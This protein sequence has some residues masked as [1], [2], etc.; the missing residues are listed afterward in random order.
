[1]PGEDCRGTNVPWRSFPA[2]CYTRVS[3][4]ECGGWRWVW[5]VEVGVGVEARER[6]EGWVGG[7][8]R[9]GVCEWGEVGRS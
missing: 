3:Y 2:G 8:G 1:M 9:R 7:I 5:R 6:G 4:G